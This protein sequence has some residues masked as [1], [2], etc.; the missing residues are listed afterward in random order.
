MMK[1]PS[2]TYRIQLN[3]HFNFHDLEAIIGYLH[4]LGISTI[5]ASPITKAFKG[6]QHGYDVADPRVINPEIGNES[7]LQNLALSLQEKGMS[8][9]Q[10]IVPNHMVYDSSNPWLYDVLERGKA[11]GYYSFFDITVQSAELIG[12]KVMAPFLGDTLTACLQKGELIL[13]F[14]DRGFGIR[15][16]DAIYPVAA[17]LYP[18]ICTVAEGCPPV[19]TDAVMALMEASGA[20]TPVW[21]AAKEKWLAMVRADEALSSFVKRRISFFNER[22]NLLENLLDGQYYVLTHATLAASYINYRRFFTVNSLICLR[23]EEENVFDAYHEQLHRWYKQ[24]LIQGLRIDHIDGL[25]APKTY[26]DRLKKLFGED[27]YMIA[28]KILSPRGEAMPENWQLEG[29]TGYEFLQLAGQVLTDADGSR[30]LLDFYSRHII[31]LPAYET[32]VYE[33]KYDFLRRYMGGELDNL[34]DRHDDDLLKEA[35]ATLMAAFPVYR[36]YPDDS[37]LSGAQAGLSDS[38]AGLSSAQAGFLMAGFDRAG[39]IRP[40]LSAELAFLRRRFDNDPAFRS[41]LMQFTGPLAAKGVEDTTFYV[42]NPYIAHNEVGDSPAVAGITVDEFHRQMKQRLA[43]LPYSLNATSTHDTKR[44]EDSR[45]RLQ[46]LSARPQE[47]ITA[48]LS[49]RQVNSPLIMQV[50]G[51]PAPSPNDEYL[52]YQALLGGLPE[53]LI[54]TDKFRERCSGYLTKALREAK[55]ETNYD[56]PDEAYEQQCRTFTM[57]ILEP[58][59][60]FM[61]TFIPI[62]YT[63]IRDS[64]PYSLSL[65]LLKLATPGIPDI[66]QGAELWET[67]F[68]DPDNRRPVDFGLRAGLL[69]Q[70]KRE[71]SVSQAAALEFV[72]ANQEKGAAKLFTIYRALGYRNVHPA[73]FTVGEYIPVTVQGARLAFIR[74]HEQDWALV[75]VPLIMPDN[76]SASLS[77]RLPPE[78]PFVW[79]DV[80]TGKR[81]ESPGAVLELKEGWNRFPVAMLTGRS[82]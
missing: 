35:L 10:D 33:K 67:S 42:Y 59:S 2:C 22:M 46:L 79:T 58:D 1:I 16:Y 17:R 72:L 73:V 34:M 3:D 28:E 27:C 15:Y 45:I 77:L 11:S 13:Q 6:S 50:G 81:Y 18:W 75:I 47:W 54:V 20:A 51:R 14:S 62:A 29:M 49:W 32:L 31:A 4:E 63:V 36:V 23:M 43:T 19:L 5:Y 82:A 53:D 48:V 74:R 56:N 76:A 26:I 64:L 44:G 57:A 60:A 55:T 8:W 24:G 41:R 40:D 61:E 71:E 70:I 39:E 25:A 30:Q 65:L 38:Q 69:Q 9:L 7:T 78:A 80:F 37:P 21:T 66:Y 12:D 68:V 52:I